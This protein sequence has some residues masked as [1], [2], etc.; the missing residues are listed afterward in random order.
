MA[1]VEARL[2]SK[3]KSFE[4][5]VDLDK[6]L[7]VKKGIP[8]SMENVL[9]VDQIFSDVKKGMRPSGSELR[10]CFGTEDTKAIAEKI[11]KQGE[12]LLPAEYRKKEQENK[13]KQVVEFLSKNAV[14]PTTGKP[15][16]QSRIELAIEQ[17]I[18]KILEKLK[19]II[20]IKIETKKLRVTVPAVH[21]GK[22]YGILKE[23]KE[24]EEWL[25]NGDLMCIINLP[26]G[27][28]IDFYDKLNSITHG[29]SIVEEIKE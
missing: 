23:Y 8:V 19:H 28:Q 27:L 29:S 20:P 2:K 24:K 3:G 22:A 7:Q 5:L 12:V 21:T 17:Q 18:G 11:I 10:E 14:D 15:H 6:A 1:N 16:T 25:A 13:E 4:I 9:A 26:A